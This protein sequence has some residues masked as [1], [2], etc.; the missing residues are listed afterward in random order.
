M[1]SVGSVSVLRRYPVK[2][3]AGESV[4]AAELEQRGLVDDRRWAIYTEDGGIASGK[5]TRRFRAVE[6]L[7]RWRATLGTGI[8]TLHSPDGASYPADDPAAG[9]ALTEAF[10]RPLALR[11]ETAI[12]HHDEAAVHLVTTSSLRSVEHYVVGPVDPRRLRMNVVIATEGAGFVEDEWLG[13][14]LTIGPDV[15]LRVGY[16]M[17]RCVMVDQ[18][19]A[20]VAAGPPI[21][22]A[23]GQCHD[24][25]LG[26][27]ADVVTPGRISVGDEVRISR[28]SVWSAPARSAPA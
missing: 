17:P 2:S 11:T 7:L 10:G 22:R 3:V 13:A 8:P 5:T 23:L 15:V 25:E 19:H 24:V 1:E 27:T 12:P 20:D 28:P 16:G 21:L 26:V 18:R 9:A 14:L 4:P 6:G